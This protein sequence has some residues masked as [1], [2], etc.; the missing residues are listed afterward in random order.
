V[1]LQAQLDAI[2]AVFQ[3]NR[4]LGSSLAALKAGLGLRQLCGPAMLPPLQPLPPVEQE[5]ILA[6]LHQLG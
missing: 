5:A 2:G 4:P 6:E 3:R 1:Q